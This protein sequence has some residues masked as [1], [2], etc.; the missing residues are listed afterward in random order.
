MAAQTLLPNP[1]CLT[2]DSLCVR[3]GAIIFAVRTTQKAVTCPLCQHTAQR[4]HSRYHRKLLDLPWQGNAV[5]FEITTRKLFCDNGN[6]E[7][8]IFTEPLPAVAARYAR[9]TCRLADALRELTYLVGG[10]AAARI[11]KTFGLLLSPDALLAALKKA[12]SPPRQT[13]RVLGI[14]DFAFRRG[15]TYGTILVDLEKHCPVDMLPDREASTV[16]SWLNAHPGVEVISRDRGK[17]YREGAARGA[18]N[19]IQV[20]DR[21]HLLKNLGDTLEKFLARKHK[22]IKAALSP[23]TATPSVLAAPSP[24]AQA[25]VRGDDCR[26]RRE[27]RLTRY[28]QII[29]LYQSGMKISGISRQTGLCR[30]TIRTYLTSDGFPERR[31]RLTRAGKLTPFQEY[32]RRRFSDGCHNAAELHKEISKR[33]YTGQY[34]VVKAFVATLRRPEPMSTFAEDQEAKKR[35]A[36]FSP[37]RLS[38][39][40]TNQH[41]AKV[42]ESDRLSVESLVQTCPEIAS[43]AALGTQFCTL[44]RERK[45]EA[46]PIWL[47]AARQSAVAELRTFAAGLRTDRAAVEAALSC[48]WSNGQ[49]EG[50]VNRLKFVKRQMY[51]RASFTLLR[52]R[53]LPNATFVTA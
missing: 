10:E 9:K 15:H 34:T 38:W 22:I 48:E 37:R 51:G 26:A 31:A 27:G 40:L 3:D 43:A 45:A 1:K 13:P 49:V 5:R 33:G 30:H 44:V 17:F 50:Q 41:S 32:I 20:A 12:M 16:E 19:A 6:C 28:E 2:L 24:S 18:P 53:V 35:R 21:W 23:I 11:A 52:A 39:V 42:S 7:R 8:R 29:A 46:L 4:V 14:D 36:L 25:M 47:E